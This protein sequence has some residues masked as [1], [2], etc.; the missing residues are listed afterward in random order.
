MRRKVTYRLYP[1]VRQTGMLE[2]Q[3][4]QHRQLYN[5]ALEQRIAAYRMCRATVT[6]A[7]QCRSLTVLR[8]DDPFWAGLNAQSEQVTLKRV[9]LAYAGF[10]RRIREGAAKAG[11]PRFKSK[12]RFAGWGYK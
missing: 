6:Y 9:D 3:L 8:A 1:T 2:Q 10:F 11:F 7:Q 12:R 5:C 4:E